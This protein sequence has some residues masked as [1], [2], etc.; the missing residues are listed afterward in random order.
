M[1]GGLHSN[2]LRMGVWF[3]EIVVCM[4][5]HEEES[6]FLTAKNIECQVNLSSDSFHLKIICVLNCI[7]GSANLYK[8]REMASMLNRL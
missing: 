3:G 2:Q 6:E 1:M 8:K 4:E 5:T 7:A